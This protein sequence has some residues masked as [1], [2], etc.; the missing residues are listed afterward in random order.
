MKVEWT[1][2]VHS[3]VFSP[4]EGRPLQ[5]RTVM[6]AM[7]TRACDACWNTCCS[8]GSSDRLSN[9]GSSPCSPS[10]CTSYFRSN[11]LPLF[12]LLGGSGA[13]DAEIRGKEPLAR[14]KGR[15]NSFLFGASEGSSLYREDAVPGQWMTY[16]RH[17]THANLPLWHGW[18]LSWTDPLELQ[19]ET[20][21]RT[22]WAY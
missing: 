13:D 21:V 19:A 17:P 6:R 15:V 18:Y 20:W 12:H 9:A 7:R 11:L 3:P 14:Q 2:I 22:E 16:Q 5:R 8:C 1:E 4:F 10:S